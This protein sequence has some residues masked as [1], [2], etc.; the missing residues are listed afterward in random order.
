VNFDFPIKIAEEIYA[1]WEEYARYWPDSKPTSCPPLPVLT[2]I[3]NT[4]FFASLK[5]EEG[6]PTQFNL[7]LCKSDTLSNPAFRYSKYTRIFNLM[8]FDSPRVFSA[9]EL[10]RLAPACEP[11][12]TLLLVSQVEKE[13][14]LCLW[15]IVDVG[16]DSCVSLVELQVGVIAPGELKIT[17]HGRILCNYKN[18]QILFPERSLVNSG[19]IYRFF[20]PTSLDL[21]REVMAATRQ[22]PG[23]RIHERDVRA[24]SYLLTW[25]KIAEKIHELKHGGCILIVPEKGKPLHTDVKYRCDDRTIWTCLKG[26]LILHDQY[27]GRDSAAPA[28]HDAETATSLQSEMQDVE[29]GLRDALDTVAR[30]T[31]V[32]GA[33]VVNRKLAL[34]GFGAV[35]KLGQ[36][37]PYEVFRCEDRR[38]TKKKKITVES[39]GTRHRS[40]FEFCFH[41]QPSVAIVVSQDAGIKT[42][43]RVGKHVYFWENVFFDASTEI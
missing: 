24:M 11:E 41:N 4:C 31:A 30:L 3:L 29:T 8:R 15:G 38:A 17:L 2:E 20:K 27:C 36:T 25:Q 1:H 32:D 40:A 26:K 18:G 34:I 21:A 35:V 42:V 6:R 43:T 22:K 14:G 10:V 9:S 13:T 12:K 19:F 7:V 5:Q 23:R 28:Q 33:V 37:A 16:K 39:Y